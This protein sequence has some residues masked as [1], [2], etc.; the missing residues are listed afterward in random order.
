MISVKTIFLALVLVV[1]YILLSLPGVPP[2]LGRTIAISILAFASTS[3]CFLA[4][5]IP[6]MS[7]ISVGPKLR[8]PEFDAI[9][10]KLER[11]LRL[12]VLGLGALVFFFFTLPITEDVIHLCAGEKPVQ[13]VE[14]PLSASTPFGVW[15]LVQFIRFSPTEGSYSLLYSFTRVHAGKKYEF[16]TLPESHMVLEFH[17]QE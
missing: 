12:F 15:F 17:E 14:T 2:W 16:L 5:L 1:P 10:P 9:R 7:L 8:R 6:K 4:G 13:I 11:N 3:F